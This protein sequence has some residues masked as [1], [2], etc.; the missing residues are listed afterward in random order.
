M[1]QPP[2][3]N[4]SQ[5]PIAA[6]VRH[7]TVGR[8]AAVL[9]HPR[10]AR[11]ARGR[12][13]CARRVQWPAQLPLRGVY[14]FTEPGEFR[15]DTGT[16]PRIVRVGTH[17]L[18]RGSRTTLW[19]RLSQHRGT[20]H[21]GGGSHRGL[22]FR[23]IVGTALIAR[24][25]HVCPTWDDRR[26]AASSAIRSAE[27]DLERVVSKTIAAMRFL[28][29][30]INDDPGEDSNRG[31]VE[32]NAIA[33]LSNFGKEPLDAPSPAWLG[34]YC[35]RPRIRAS[36]LWNANHVDENYDPAFLDKLEALVQP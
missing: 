25:G 35:N 30:D 27:L 13:P 1:P 17:A 14:F 3:D 22:I 5:R 33:L 28:W 8:L 34:Q 10:R 21:S 32:R 26:S 6:I 2:N 9:S 7:E 31:Y 18:K 11:R 15:S 36:G 12:Q 23:L 24:D 20:G 16:G 19:K 4:G 29:L